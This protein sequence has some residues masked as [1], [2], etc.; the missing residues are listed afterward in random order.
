MRTFYKTDAALVGEFIGTIEAAYENH[1]TTGESIGVDESELN[2][3][4]PD[5]VLVYLQ[6][7]AAVGGR[8]APSPA[9]EHADELLA[10]LQRALPWL[11]KLI[12]DGG[13]LNSVAPNDAVGAMQQ[14]E[15]AIKK[16]L[17]NE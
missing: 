14:A 8:K 2:R 13:H 11:G 1:P 3:E 15:A 12:A 10:A 7:K 6:A 4:W 9:V 5:L 16:A 17:G